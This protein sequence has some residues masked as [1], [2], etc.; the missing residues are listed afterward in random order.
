MKWLEFAGLIGLWVVAVLR[1]PGAVRERHQRD[2]WLAVVLVA[3]TTTI[4][5]EPVV[6][7]LAQHIG[8]PR[9]IDMGRHVCDIGAS[10][11]LLHLISRVTNRRPRTALLLAAALSVVVALLLLDFA[12]P[13][14]ARSNLPAPELPSAFWATLFGYNLIAN[15]IVATVCLR[16][17]RAAR[18]WPLRWSL[19]T[20]G[21]GTALVCLVWVMF[22]IYVFQRDTAYLRYDSLIIGVEEILRAVGAGLP[23][24]PAMIRYVK[25]VGAVWQLWPLWAEL[26]AAAPHVALRRNRFR[27]LGMLTAV[28]AVQLRLYR[29]VIEIRDAMLVLDDY[30]APSVAVR[31]D[32]VSRGVPARLRDAVRIACL[33]QAAQRAKLSRSVHPQSLNAAELGGTN[34]ESELAFLLDVTRVRRSAAVRGFIDQLTPDGAV[35]LNP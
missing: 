34:F 20:F 12:A 19:L 22:L 3:V 8:S 32:A 23:L 14:H 33:M 16:Y 28:F 15:V 1:A 35:V 30:I 31:V 11:V 26:T 10:T 29:M 24:V 13:P 17:W 6:A 9:L 25:N 5:E 4:Y 21:A 18:E 7:W 2:L 27:A